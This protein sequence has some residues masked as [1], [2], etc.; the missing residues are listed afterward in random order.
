[1]HY[2]SL[3]K[4]NIQDFLFNKPLKVYLLWLFFISLLFLVSC[5]YLSAKTV[6]FSI[7]PQHLSS[8]YMN[9]RLLDSVALN[10]SSIDSLPITE[11]SDIAWDE[12]ENILYAISDEGLLYSLQLVIKNTKLQ[13]LEVISAKQLKDING[14][15]LTGNYRDSEGLTLLNSSNKKKGDSQLIISFENRPRIARFTTQGQLLTNI[16]IPQKISKKKF[17]RHKN[18]AL[19]S[20]INHPKYGILTAAEKPIK[21]QLSELQTIYSNKNKE[22]HFFVSPD[23]GSAI[24]G[25]EVLPNGDV[26]ILERAY[27]NPW[28]PIVINLRR[29][30]LEKCNKLRICETETLARFDGIDGWHLDNFEGI[31]QIN[32]NLYLMVS[33][34]NNN[35]FQT[36]VWVLFEVNPS[37]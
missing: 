28:T 33:D 19:E 7:T 35:P 1:M 9:I 12:D 31:T 27:Q 32:D 2:F 16:K 17:F 22:W 25:L 8:S 14:I 20:V 11:L 4:L 5:N 29:L 21:N 34:N 3:S 36:T 23:K 26:L 10:A 24:T 15:P 6:K 37:Q 13:T 18:N 30:M